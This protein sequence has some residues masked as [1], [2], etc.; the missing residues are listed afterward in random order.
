MERW[1]AKSAHTGN[2]L[3]TGIGKKRT[4]HQLLPPSQG[5]CWTWLL[6]YHPPQWPQWT[7]LWQ[8]ESCN[9]ASQ[10]HPS[11][12]FTIDQ[13]GLPHEASWDSRLCLYTDLQVG[14]AWKVSQFHPHLLLTPLC[15]SHGVVLPVPRQPRPKFGIFTSNTSKGAKE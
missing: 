3:L 6:C 10:M 4:Q 2:C 12:E 9:W 15:L 5:V 14:R 11:H 13:W 1:K 7:E 8:R